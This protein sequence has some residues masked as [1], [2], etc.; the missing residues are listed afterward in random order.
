[1]RLGCRLKP[2]KQTDLVKF[3]IIFGIFM[4]HFIPG[5]VGF[6]ARLSTFRRRLRQPLPPLVLA[7]AVG[8]GAD[9]Q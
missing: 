8:T 3:I 4:G 1:M 9:S 6:L 2:S 7:P 5:P